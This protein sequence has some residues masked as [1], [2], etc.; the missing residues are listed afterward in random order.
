MK[1]VFSSHKKGFALQTCFKKYIVKKN[2]TFSTTFYFC[3]EGIIII[4]MI[5]MMIIMIIIIIMIIMIIMIIIIIII[6][7]C[8]SVCVCV[9]VRVP[10]CV[11]VCVCVCVCVCAR[12]ARACVVYVCP[13]LTGRA[14]PVWLTKR[15]SEKLLLLSL[16]PS[17]F[18]SNLFEFDFV[19]SLMQKKKKIKVIAALSSSV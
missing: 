2:Q 16:L 13:A 8:F 18:Q 14:R 7:V 4:I 19:A 3:F 10:V 15:K 9:Y 12:A 5:I 1:K 17:R 11:P 6:P